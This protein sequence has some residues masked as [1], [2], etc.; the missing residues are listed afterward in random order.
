MFAVYKDNKEVVEFL[1]ANKA[2][3]HAV[4]QAGCSALFIAAANGREGMVGR[5][6]DMGSEIDHPDGKGETPVQAALRKQHLGAVGLLLSRGAVADAALLQKVAAARAKPERSEAV[7][8]VFAWSGDDFA[9]GDSADVELLRSESKAALSWFA[10]QNFVPIPTALG[11]KGAAEYCFDMA[12]MAQNS[13]VWKEAWAGFHQALRRYA[14]LGED[15]MTGLTC[16]N[17]GKVYGA[18]SNWRMAELMFRQSAGLASRGGEEKGLAWALFY[19]GDVR[20]KR[21][22]KS[23]CRYYWVLAQ[24]IFDRISPGD[25][26]NVEAALAKL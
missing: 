23:E 21:G 16:F 20:Q 7:P 25:A 3:I 13:G 17:L 10:A 4:N 5:L 2:N 12:T 6:L 8:P 22:D 26:R 9:G 11:E 1:A 24:Q 15:K 18:Q 19:L 14:R